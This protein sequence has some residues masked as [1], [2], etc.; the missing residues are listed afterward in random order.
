M[1]RPAGITASAIVLGIDAAFQAL[2][3]F[4]LV[5][6]AFRA[7]S[8]RIPAQPGH[9]ALPPVTLAAIFLVGAL[10]FLFLAIWSASTV[11]GLLRISNWARYSVLII[12]GVTAA[13]GLLC[14][15]A[16][17]FAASIAKDIFPHAPADP[18]A[19]ALTFVFIAIFYLFIA[20]IGAW[21]LVYFNLRSTRNLFLVHLSRPDAPVYAA[22]YHRPISITLLG[23]LFLV[24]SLACFA[25]IFLPFPAFLF[26]LIFYG[27]LSKFVFTFFFLLTFGIGIGLLRLQN[28]ARLGA[29][30]LI[31]AACANLLLVVNPWYR[32]QF[33]RFTDIFSRHLAG[34]PNHPIPAFHTFSLAV[35]CIF[36]LP[37]YAVIL[38]LLH[39]H[40]QSFY[41]TTAADPTLS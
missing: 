25:Q 31:L 38:W 36:L 21:W 6:A 37:L 32:L 17:V 3:G 13:F 12:G 15:L 22:G 39:R 26:G 1:K 27:T 11:A 24:A 4:F 16:T 2:F 23:I 40:R 14:A 34:T 10:T 19:L 29:M 35:G 30:L 20:S 33:D 18:H 28:L 5:F 9:A 7:H 8:G 41:P